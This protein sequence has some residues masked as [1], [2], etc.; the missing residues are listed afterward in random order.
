[1]SNMRGVLKWVGIILGGLIVVLLVAFGI[2][3]L[4]SEAIQNK[5]YEAPAIHVTVPQDAAAVER[6]QHMVTVVSECI[7]C[8]GPDLS[9]GAIIDDPAIGRLVAPNL[10]TG[11]GGF[12]SVLSDDDIAR[13]LRYG[14]LPDGKSVRIMPADDYTNF[15]DAD[16]AAVIAYIRS[17]PPVDTNHAPSRLGP[18]GRVLLVTGQLPI[19]VAPRIDFAEA[20]SPPVEMGPTHDY[21]AYLISVAGCIGCH[22]PGLSGGVIPGAPPGFP[23]SAN[24][25][26]SG[27]VGTWT[28][29]DFINTIRTGVNPAG[30]Q[31]LEE[32]PW[33]TYRN[34]TDDEL[35]ALW[36]FIDT[37]PAKE[38]GTR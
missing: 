13:V 9:G 23:Q 16:L 1:M 12:G 6:G 15:T 31:L 28:E 7:G 26:P 19:M 10:T 3:Y 20:G 27:E 38:A 4:Q 5:K 30:H 29:A 21:G 35:K 33:K 2:V 37:V 17:L 18:M 32:M 22:G 36:A 8:H 34:M 25:T 11:A 14:V 24:L